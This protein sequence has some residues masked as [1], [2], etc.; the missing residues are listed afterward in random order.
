MSSS[1]P[2]NPYVPGTYNPTNWTTNT[3]TTSGITLTQLNDIL[4]GYTQYPTTQGALTLANNSTATTQSNN[5]NS[6]K[7]ATTLYVNNE[8]NYVFNTPQTLY[9]TASQ[10]ITINPIY[11]HYDIIMVG[12]GGRPGGY[13]NGDVAPLA[14]GGAG[15]S[16]GV[17]AYYGL[18]IDTINLYSQIVLNMSYL[19]PSS[20]LVYIGG[21]ATL[22]GS[23]NQGNTGASPSGFTAGAAGG[24]G[25]SV[26]FGTITG[27]RS[28]Q[29]TTGGTGGVGTLQSVNP[30]T[31]PSGGVPSITYGDYGKGGSNSACSG[32]LTNNYFYNLSQNN[33]ISG[34]IMI[35]FYP[36]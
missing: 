28:R 2:P 21:V 14:L 15:G 22:I 19:N 33:G 5:D 35:T 3:T 36:Y 30:I 8:I 1:N 4:A 32:Y 9:Y 24:T 11:K 23:G 13:V 12:G 25:G 20:A 7:I 16:G 6:T 31:I 34:F 10:T 26:D 29:A 17:C 18:P 27:Y